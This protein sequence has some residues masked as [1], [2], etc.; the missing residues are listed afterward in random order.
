MTSPL[1]SGIIAVFANTRRLANMTLDNSND[2][3]SQQEQGDSNI[4]ILTQPN[5]ESDIIPIAMVMGQQY[6]QMPQDLYIPPDALRIFLEA[7]EGPLDLLL[8]LIKREN[9][10]IL[11]LPIAEITKQYMEYVEFMRE[12]RFELAAEYLLMAAMLAEIKSRLLLPKPVDMESDEE[13]PR[14]ELIRRLQEYEQ[15]KSASEKLDNIPREGRDFF[16]VQAE[17]P[18]LNQII[19]YPDLSLKELLTAFKD[20][21]L[22]AEMSVSHHVQL[23]SLSIRE[24]MSNILENIKADEFTEF[25]HLFDIRRGRLGVVV[26]FLAILELLKQAMI[27]LVQNEPFT[28]IYIKRVSEINSLNITSDEL[29]F[30]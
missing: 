26:S 20:V 12:L 13:D 22:R 8:Y 16:R 4:D 30:H 18:K 24:T 29:D 14:A 11:D 3:S 10:D 1:T 23:E 19:T 21:L 9:I 2:V 15:I 7:F 6:L 28:P 27:E 17:P 25:A 5:S